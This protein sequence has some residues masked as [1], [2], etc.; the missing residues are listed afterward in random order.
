M[1]LTYTPKKKK[2]I[3]VSAN[4]ERY[5][6]DAYIDFQEKRKNDLGNI[7]NEINRREQE[8]YHLPSM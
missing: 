6:C 4:T 1:K 2:A 7:I 5:R 8:K 3:K